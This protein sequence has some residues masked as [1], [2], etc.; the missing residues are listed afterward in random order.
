M[1]RIWQVVIVSILLASVGF[2]LYHYAGFLTT[3]KQVVANVTATQ[4]QKDDFLFQVSVD[5]STYRY[6]E[7]IT[8][9]FNLT[10]LGKSPRLIYLS[11]ESS[12]FHLIVRNATHNLIVNELMLADPVEPYMFTFGRSVTGS[13]IIYDNNY[14][15]R[16]KL[17]F[18][19]ILSFSSNNTY[20]IQ[21]RMYI[22]KNESSSDMIELISPQVRI[23]INK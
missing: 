13:A 22:I 9:Y 16:P 3:P 15:Y 11:S 4:V 2:G 5:N 7:P 6:G 18:G 12:S 8:V 10:Y 1:K 14:Q 17:G 19:D 23:M 20:D 21:G